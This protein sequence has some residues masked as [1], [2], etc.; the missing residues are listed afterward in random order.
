MLPHPR[1]PVGAEAAGVKYI[2]GY[3]NSEDELRMLGP[4]S[5]E[6]A[7]SQDIRGKYLY[8]AM[9]KDDKILNS[10]AIDIEK[11]WPSRLT[12]S[13]ITDRNDTLTATLHDDGGN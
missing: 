5:Y 4:F 11:E 9:V 13:N 2:L 6:E 1:P 10:K 3:G 8:L 12:G 7:R